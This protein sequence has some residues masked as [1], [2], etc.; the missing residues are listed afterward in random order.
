MYANLFAGTD[1]AGG[2]TG[3]PSVTEIHPARPF[4]NPLP[5]LL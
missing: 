4:H 2:G 1:S 3:E 5:T